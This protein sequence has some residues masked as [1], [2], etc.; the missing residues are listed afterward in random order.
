MRRTESI[1]GGGGSPHAPL[2]GRC[3]CVR[4][5][6]WRGA[7]RCGASGLLASRH[8]THPTLH[9]MDTSPSCSAADLSAI[10]GAESVKY[11]T[12]LWTPRRATPH[13]TTPQSHHTTP[14]H[15]TPHTTPRHA[16]QDATPRHTTPRHATPRHAVVRRGHRDGFHPGRC[17]RR[18]RRRG[19]AGLHVVRW[20]D[21]HRPPSYP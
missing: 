2:G 19:A 5:V 13:R 4:V 12:T 11:R 10:T 20:A 21:G 15:T 6:M 17:R 7:A 9:Q 18:R 14:H 1:G 3:V 16:T 8:P